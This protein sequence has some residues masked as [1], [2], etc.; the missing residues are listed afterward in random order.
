[1]RKLL[2]ASVLATSSVFAV[3]ACTSVGATT[4]TAASTQ[5]QKQHKGS[6]K[7]GMRGGFSQLNLSAAQ[8]TQIQTIRQNSNVDRQKEREAMMNVLTTEQRAQLETMKSERKDRG[9]R[10]GHKRGNQN[11][12]TQLNLSTTQQA[13]IDTIRKNTSGDRM[14]KQQAVMAVLTNEQRAQ[15]EALKTQRQ[16]KGHRSLNK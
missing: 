2:M 9:H 7:D 6:N 12:L 14:Q 11:P 3:T 1:M 15:L 16:D 8:Q 13:Q 5:M 4:D 10:G